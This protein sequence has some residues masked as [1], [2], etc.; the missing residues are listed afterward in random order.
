MYYENPEIKKPDDLNAKIWRY[1]DFTKFLSLIMN[2]S[3]FFC[4]TDKLNDPFEGY[5]TPKDLSLDRD[6]Y[7]KAFLDSGFDGD[8][9]GLL[10]VIHK[11]SHD[12]IRSGEAHL[13]GAFFWVNCWHMN[14]TESVA[15]WKIYS[16]ENKGIAIES[17]FNRLC[18]SFNKNDPEL[19]YIGMVE[20]DFEASLTTG[21][22]INH[23][24]KKRKC[25]KYEEEVRAVLMAPDTIIKNDKSAHVDPYPD[26]LK[27][28]VDLNKL[29]QKIHISP[30]A[31]PWFFDLVNDVINHY[32]IKTGVEKSNMW[33]PPDY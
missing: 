16:G 19:V 7:R 22:P 8:V 15:M 23:V 6:R 11:K 18:Q 24:L 13:W 28:K 4:R 27:I 29:I 3:L 17:T 32:N 5:Y 30:K 33:T 21:S 10:D 2:E 14:E 26:G 25:F 12:E 9:D 20:Y 31:K 1:I